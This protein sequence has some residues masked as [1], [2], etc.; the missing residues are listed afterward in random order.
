M[1]NILVIDDEREVGNF[2]KVLLT[3]KGHPVVLAESGKETK[4]LLNQGSYG[5]AIID[6]RLPDASGLNLLKD[7]RRKFPACKII[8]MTGYSTVKTAVEAIKLGADD[9]IEKPFDDIDQLE[10]QIDDLLLNNND[11]AS[12]II[13]RIANE[14][15]F[16]IGKHSEME[17]LA[18]IAYKIASKN[19]NVLIEGETGTGKEVLARFIHQASVR[20][21]QS[22]IGIN[23]GALSHSLLES[24]L[25]GHEKGA[26]TGAVNKRRGIF[27]IA[28]QGTLLLDEIAETSTSMQVRLLR[29]LETREYMRIGGEKSHRTNT[30]IIA[31]SHTHLK[32][33]V[34]QNK[35]RKDLFYR[36]DVV[37]LQ[38]PSLRERVNDIPLFVDHFLNKFQS[39]L[40]VSED[41]M[42]FLKKYSWP[43]NIRE[44][45]NTILHLISFNEGEKRVITPED[46][47]EKLVSGIENRAALQRNQVLPHKRERDLES[48]L[49]EWNHKIIRSLKNF[50]DEDFTWIEMELKELQQ[51]VSKAFVKESLSLSDGNRK[52]AARRLNITERK[53]RYILNE[54]DKM[55][56]E[57]TGR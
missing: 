37:K 31:A 33:A 32:D 56:Q 44:L 25:F 10:K 8:I 51:Q 39:H 49:S 9:Y 46:L 17:H 52:D 24:E 22:F 15:G 20:R 42:Y 5:L 16:L 19:V 47:P 27:E 45:S 34:T 2:L 26:F 21:D 55:I 40:K 23:C 57:Q 29:V 50:S 11:V 7:I 43:G 35:F 30:R 3:E 6:V 36:L 41:A 1:E 12:N 48:Y 38:L 18:A 28:S 53:L 13:H 4:N 54:K 14:I